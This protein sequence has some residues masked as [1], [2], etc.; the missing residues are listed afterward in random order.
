MKLSDIKGERTLEVVADIIE[1]IANIAA[2]ED[3]AA[4][5]KKEKLPEGKSVREFLIERLTR[6]LPALLKGH[7][8]D[9]IRILATIEGVSP[10]EYGDELNLAKLLQDITELLNDEAFIA[11][12]I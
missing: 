2:D 1:P 11:L 7:K 4:L 3:A 6:S 10:G 9:V 12:F 8:H 5:F